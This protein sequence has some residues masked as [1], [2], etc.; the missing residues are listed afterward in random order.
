MS[1]WWCYLSLSLSQ[2]EAETLRE[3]VIFK[4]YCLSEKD[5]ELK[6]KETII[7][8]LE[9]DIQV[10]YYRTIFVLNSIFQSLE[11]QLSLEM[12]KISALSREEEG[13]KMELASA[14]SENAVLVKEIGQLRKELQEKVST[15]KLLYNLTV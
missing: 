8:N 13:S 3:E 14:L 2:D 6:N 10:L 4:D 12:D 1:E 9:A 15:Y 11:E 5:Q 7:V